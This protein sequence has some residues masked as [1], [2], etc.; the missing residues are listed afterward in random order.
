MEVTDF[1]RMVIAVCVGTVAV[2]AVAL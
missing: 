1:Q 2:L